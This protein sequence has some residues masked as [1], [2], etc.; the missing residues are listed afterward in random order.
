[1]A[2]KKD[3]T[4]AELY[5]SREPYLCRA[6]WLLHDSEE[7]KDV[8]QES[9]AALMRAIPRLRGEASLSTVLHGIFLRQIVNCLRRR[10][11]EAIQMGPLRVDDEED[12]LCQHEADTAHDGGIGKVEALRELVV[13]VRGETPGALEVAYLYLVEGY[14]FGQIGKKLGFGRKEASEL[15]RQLVER[16]HR[17][18]GHESR[19]G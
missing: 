9:F 14:T 19:G 6:Q 1:M 3:D 10:S 2:K 17:Q 11:R 5:D 7:A 8:V 16:T 13:L 4:L 12:S 18:G 15:M